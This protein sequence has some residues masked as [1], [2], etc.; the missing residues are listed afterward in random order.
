MKLSSFAPDTDPTIE[1]VITDCEGVVP[2]FKG[3]AGA[4]S[5]TDSLLAALSATVNGAATLLKLDG[6]SRT[7]AGQ[8][9]SIVEASTATWGDVSKTTVAAYATVLGRWRFAQYGNVSIAASKENTLQYSSSNLF[10]DISGGPKADIV[11]TVGQFV[12]LF[13]TNESTYGDSP[14]RWWCSALGDYTNWTPSIATQSATNTL[15]SVPGK[16]TAGKRFGD[17]VVVFKQYGMYVG[18]YSG[19]PFIWSFQELPT[20][21]IGTFC[22]E[23]VA[24]IGTPEQ[25]KLFF[26]GTDNFYLFDGARPIPVGFDVKTYFFSN[27]N[28]SAAEKICILHDR[29]YARL[30]IYFPSGSSTVLNNC[31]VYN[32]RTGKWGKDPRTIDFAIEF[33]PGGLTYADLGT[34]YA[35]YNDLPSAPYSNAFVSG[36]SIAPAIFNSSHKLQTMNGAASTGFMVTGDYGDDVNEVLLSRVKVKWLTKPTSATM[37]NYYRQHIGDTLTQDQTVTMS[38]SRFDVLREARWHRA[39]INTVGDWEANMVNAD[40]AINGSE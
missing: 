5:P 23:S 38:E 30:Y 39:K 28:V 22:Q 35:T 20:G 26:V 34:Y 40:F 18:I 37:T 14:N 19:P 8:I 16:I 31:L 24:Q 6:T 12:F 25:P 27:L 2:S 15:T 13:N 7:F 10:A 11:E 36:A 3:L 9:T 29:S 33:I 1:G 21:G 4:P 17:S 32:Y